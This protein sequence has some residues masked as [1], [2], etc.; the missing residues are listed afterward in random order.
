MLLG[1]LGGEFPVTALPMIAKGLGLDPP[2]PGQGVLPLDQIDWIIATLG[3]G[4]GRAVSGGRPM[5]RID[6]GPPTIQMIKPFDWLGFLRAWHIPL[7]PV[8]SEGHTYYQ[9]G[10]PIKCVFVGKSPCVY[11]PDSR[12]IVF[13]EEGELLKVLGRAKPVIASFLSGM[14]WERANRGLVAIVI[15]NTRGELSKEYDLGRPDD[16]IVVDLFRNVD[17]W[18]FSVDDTDSATIHA[19]AACNADRGQEIAGLAESHLKM[20]RA[21][22]QARPTDAKP[23]SIHQRGWHMLGALMQNAR[24]THERP[25]G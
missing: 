4:P 19:R 5:H 9:I 18:I 16:K 2:A 14:D 12:T 22:L 7:T 10:G 17:H 15:D 21:S 6:I 25:L 11:L 1:E 20:T 8:R 3:F 24:V 23:S 13:K